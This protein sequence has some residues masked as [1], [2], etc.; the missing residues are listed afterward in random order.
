MI[1]RATMTRLNI[2]TIEI[3]MAITDL[4]DEVTYTAQHLRTAPKQSYIGIITF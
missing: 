1:L 3:E 2:F 4:A